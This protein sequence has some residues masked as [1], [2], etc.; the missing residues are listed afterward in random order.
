[1]IKGAIFDMD[2]LLFDTETLYQQTW[3]ELADERV[4]VLGNDFT[5]AIS[6]TNGSY[7]CEVLK[8]Y[9]KVSD[10]KVI[11]EEGMRRMTKKLQKSVP[12]KKGVRE[13]LGCLSKHHRKLAVASSTAKEQI[14][15]NLQV[16]GIRE[17][18][19]EII[20]AEEVEHGKPAPDIFLYAAEKIHCKPEE[21]YAF[22]DSFNGVRAGVAANCQTIMIP[23]LFQATEEMYKIC[24]GVYPDLLRAME[25]E[26]G[27]GV[28]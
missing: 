1:M 14:E 25:E 23:D 6:G 13:I 20:S 18:F 5:G 28:F 11:M 17:Y 2:G 15:R 19:D 22:E 8:K 26:F 4:I 16:A 10:G 3:R 21:C 12:L 7:M 24:K 9:Y 27:T